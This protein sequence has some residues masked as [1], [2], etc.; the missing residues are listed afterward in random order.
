MYVN[1][2]K[3]SV[4]S[5]DICHN[6]SVWYGILTCR[7]A[8]DCG[9]AVVLLLLVLPSSFLAHSEGHEALKALYAHAD[10]WVK[11]CNSPFLS[12]P[13]A[14]C[15]IQDM[16]HPIYIPHIS[17]PLL[18]PKLDEAS[19]VFHRIPKADATFRYVMHPQTTFQTQSGL[20][21]PIKR[22]YRHLE[23]SG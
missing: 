10:L 23:G 14:N 3:T 9:F 12:V 6:I 5:S 1:S 13:P 20:V 8:C 19:G 16:I 17:H 21:T 11:V 15:C 2:T 4:P 7:S 22:S 18:A